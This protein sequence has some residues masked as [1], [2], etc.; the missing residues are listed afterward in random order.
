MPDH[1]HLDAIHVA[2]P[3]LGYLV[4]KPRFYNAFLKI[5]RMEWHGYF[6]PSD[7]QNSSKHSLFA[8]HNV[9]VKFF[10]FT[11]MKVKL[12]TRSM[13]FS[14][15]IFKIESN[16]FGNRQSYMIQAI[17]QGQHLENTIISRIYSKAGF[18]N[19]MFSRYIASSLSS[20][21]NFWLRVKQ[22]SIT[23]GVFFQMD[24]DVIIWNN[25][26]YLSQPKL[27]SKEDVEIGKYRKWCK[28]FY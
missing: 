8:E 18:L 15:L 2:P 19:N 27:L 1:Q 11:P 12:I 17:I 16:F 21:V 14:L 6:N 10:N 4:K 23:H 9:Q 3:Y 26:K 13:G 20:Q 25:K 24:R 5:L 28:Q 22:K 7:S